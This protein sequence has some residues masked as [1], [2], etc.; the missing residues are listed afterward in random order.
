M[1]SLEFGSES[2]VR[3]MGRGSQVTGLPAAVRYR[4]D[5]DRLDVLRS[6]LLSLSC[7]VTTKRIDNPCREGPVRASWKG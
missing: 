3:T 5:P 4:A 1:R 7:E 2:V 6:L